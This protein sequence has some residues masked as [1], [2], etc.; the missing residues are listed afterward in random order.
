M[1]KIKNL[2]PHAVGF[3]QGGIEVASFQSE[4]QVRLEEKDDKFN[5][6]P[7]EN[8]TVPTC[9]RRY[10][11]GTLPEQ[12]DG[13]ILIVSQIVCE[14]FPKRRDLYFPAF[15]VRDTNGKFIGTTM[16]CQVP[17]EDAE[18]GEDPFDFPQ[19]ATAKAIFPDAKG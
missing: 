13:V 5:Y 6:L 19:Y 11:S 10:G 2:T 15:D 14:A 1:Y 8:G 18:S 7:F 3:F 9:I 17:Q 4:G 16:L 12:E